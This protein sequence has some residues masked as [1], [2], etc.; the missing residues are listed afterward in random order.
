MFMFIFHASHGFGL[1]W[2]GSR[3][4]IEYQVFI[5]SPPRPVPRVSHVS[6][7]MSHLIMDVMHMLYPSEGVRAC[8]GCP[9]EACS[10]VMSASTSTAYVSREVMPDGLA[11]AEDLRDG[12]D[13]CDGY[14]Q[15]TEYRMCT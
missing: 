15:N 1:V 11:L 2:S 12:C 5:G 10:P 4:R 13:G 9:L 3:A 6:C 7:L 14:T 8:L